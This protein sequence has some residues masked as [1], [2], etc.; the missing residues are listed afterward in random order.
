MI[1]IIIALTVAL[2]LGFTTRPTPMEKDI[3]K[4]GE[5]LTVLDAKEN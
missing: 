3:K 5:V 2:V 4:E 1:A